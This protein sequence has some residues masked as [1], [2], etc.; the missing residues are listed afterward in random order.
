[1]KG[2]IF[3][4]STVV[5]VGVLLLLMALDL[6]PIDGIG[7]LFVYIPSLFILWG[8]VLLI[9][10]KFRKAAGP[11]ALIA[12]ASVVQLMLLGILWWEY[13]WPIA[14]ILVGVSIIAGA[15]G[16]YGKRKRRRERRKQRERQNAA[17]DFSIGPEIR[18]NHDGDLDISVT[19]GE[20]SESNRSKDFRGGEISCVTGSVKLDLTQAE[21]VERPA[22]I[23]V[24][25]VIGEVEILVPDHWIVQHNISKTIGEVVDNTT[26]RQA[27]ETGDDVDLIISGSLA[28]GGVTIASASHT[29]AE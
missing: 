5:L 16:T 13:V 10:R 19:I 6:V 9:S 23:N 15:T 14:I 8:L 2:T 27:T 11:I 12:I 24:D 4:G 18:V 20:V 22:R 21:V 3:F 1:M 28:I 26:S 29:V 25:L 7:E 17:A